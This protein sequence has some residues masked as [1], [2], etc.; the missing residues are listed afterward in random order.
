MRFQ[1]A[2]PV[3]ERVFS[4]TADA[5]GAF[6]F[7]SSLSSSG[8]SRPIPRT[9]FRL[10]TDHPVTAESAPTVNGTFGLLNPE[11]VQDIVFTDSGQSRSLRSSS[12]RSA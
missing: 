5:A 2:S 6:R 4:A 9:E 3:F 8:D 1:S 11:T 10:D 7:Q 12:N